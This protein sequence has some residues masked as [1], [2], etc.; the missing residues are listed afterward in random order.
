ML[1]RTDET[2]G[3]ARVTMGSEK[4]GTWIVRIEPGSGIVGW[5]AERA[6]AVISEDPKSDPRFVESVEASVGVALKNIAAVPL[7]SAFDGTPLGALAVANRRE[8]SFTDED[9]ALLE[10]IASR[11]SSAIVMMKSRAQ[12]DRDRRL[13]T[14]G[15]LLAGVLHDLKSP[16]SVIAG[17]AE[18]LAEKCPDEESASHLSHIHSNLSRITT[19]AEDIVAFSRGERR[20]LTTSVSVQELMDSFARGMRPLLTATNVTLDLEVHTQGQIRIDHDKILRAFHNIARNAVEAMGQ[21]G[22]LSVKVERLD[23]EIGFSFTDHGPGI[24]EQIQGVLFESFVT[25][26]KK[27]GTGLG[28]AVAKEIVEAHG[29]AITF[30]TKKGAGTTFVLRLPG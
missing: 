13:A 29:G 10:R 11:L 22:L 25:M 3:E 8:G 18:L 7:F 27:N 26:G 23:N 12:R 2:G 24:P 15:Q 9:L 17:Y 16:I 1:Y 6:E 21:S 5:V 19:M 28:L 4:Q 30:T 20:I 14:V